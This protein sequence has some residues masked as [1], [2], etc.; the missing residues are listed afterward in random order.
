MIPAPLGVGGPSP[1]VLPAGLDLIRE[2]VS[3][4]RSWIEVHERGVTARAA[5]SA[6][7][8]SLIAEIHARRDLFLGYLDR[9]FDEREQVFERLFEA[10]DRAMA[11]DVSSVAGVLGAITTL[12]AKSPFADLRD[13]ELVR[14][15]LADPDH[16]WT[17]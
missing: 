4:G 2:I 14:R 15:N 7:E 9:S 6:R 16:V 8:R 17:A 3:L 11:D 13:I 5:I 10:L 12:A 1:S